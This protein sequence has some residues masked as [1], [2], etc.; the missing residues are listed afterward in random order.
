MVH[1][2]FKEPPRERLQRLSG[3]LLGTLTVAD[4]KS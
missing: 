4:K 1:N 3:D 2:G